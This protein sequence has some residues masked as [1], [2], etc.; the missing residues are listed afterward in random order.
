MMYFTLCYISRKQYWFLTI[1]CM[2]QSFFGLSTNNPGNI[3]NTFHHASNYSIILLYHHNI[4]KAFQP[5][6]LL[7]CPCFFHLCLLD[8]NLFDKFLNCSINFENIVNYSILCDIYYIHA[9]TTSIIEI[10][11]H[12]FNIHLIIYYGNDYFNHQLE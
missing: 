7:Y 10:K 6:W 12:S 9:C 5:F 8:F 2:C 1:V 11:T 3:L 4:S